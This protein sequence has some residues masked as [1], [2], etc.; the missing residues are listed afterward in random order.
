[1]SLHGPFDTTCQSRLPSLVQLHPQ[2]SNQQQEV[3]PTCHS[4]DVCVKI[5]LVPAQGRLL[6]QL[7]AATAHSTHHT[8]R[9]SGSSS[10]VASA[11]GA[12]RLLSTQWQTDAMQCACA[13]MRRKQ[14]CMCAQASTGT[15]ALG[16]SDRWVCTCSRCVSW[17]HQT[18]GSQTSSPPPHTGCQ[19]L[20]CSPHWD[21]LGQCSV[22]VQCSARRT[23]ST[24]HFMHWA[25]HNP[26]LHPACPYA[27]WFPMPDFLCTACRPLD[28]AAQS[29]RTCPPNH[30]TVQ[31]TNHLTN[32]PMVEPTHTHQPTWREV[33]LSSTEGQLL[34]CCSAQGACQGTDECVAGSHVPG[35]ATR[36]PAGGV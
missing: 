3:H 10:S 22:G 34:G 8:T 6:L 14:A 30:P 20:G 25:C 27:T 23:P 17:P 11:G 33:A 21:H 12:Y 28:I 19:R 13:G 18:A 24:A 9:S 5:G 7:P 35:R 36:A 31:P 26:V 2:P 16:L 29:T 32:D 15:Q 1:M 4:L